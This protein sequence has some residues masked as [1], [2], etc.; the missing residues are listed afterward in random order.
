MPPSSDLIDRTLAVSR[1]WHPQHKV[2]MMRAAQAAAKRDELRAKYRH[3]ADLMCAVNPDFVVTPAVDMISRAVET[4]LRSRRKINLLVTMPPQEGKSTLCAVA[5]PLRALQHNPDTKVVLATYGN[6]L[7]ENHSRDCRDIIQTHGSG[8][9]DPLTGARVEDKLGFQLSRRSNKVSEWSIADAQGGLVAVGRGAAITGRRADLAIIDDPY[10]DMVEADS[11][12]IRNRVDA[13]FSAVMRTRLS[14]TASI[15]LIQTRWH[16]EDLAGKV[17]AAEKLLPTGLRSWKHINIPAIAEMG[18]PDALG[19]PYGEPMESARD[20]ELDE[21]GDVIKRDFP[22]KRLEVGERTWYALYQGSPRNPAGG[23]FLRKWFDDGRVPAAPEHPVAAIVG[24]DPADSGKGDECGVVGGMLAGNGDIIMVEDWSGQM[25]SDQ[26]AK[27]AVTLALTIGAREIA[28]EAFTTAHTY[29]QVLKRA[30]IDMQ[31]AAL[32][33][34]TAGEPL[35]QLEQKCLSPNMPFVIHKWRERGDAVAR[36]SLLRQAYELGK[37]RNVAVK[38]S[39]FEAQACDWQVG[40][41]QPD[42]VAAGVIAHDRL[43]ELSR[44]RMQTATPLG[45]RPGTAPAWLRRSVAGG[46]GGGGARRLGR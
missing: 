19:R 32:A 21:N 10:K 2:G 33:K 11:E 7:A 5:A 28:M 41:H 6:A 14:P 4:V 18:I 16:P 38:M 35:T 37:C 1:G 9:I 44:G 46:P 8:L 40:Q 39:V 20:G 25:T 45:Q 43:A 22:M 15:I 27:K 3:P 31:K 36:S 30:W 34:H 24:I 29:E 13:W 26:W 42:R 23:L 17:L 12:A